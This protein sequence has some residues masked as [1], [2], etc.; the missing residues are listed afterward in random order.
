[1]C[2]IENDGACKQV[3]FD[4]VRNFDH[5]QDK[6]K[7]NTKNRMD[8]VLTEPLGNSVGSTN[9]A[10]EEKV[11]FFANERGREYIHA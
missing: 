7:G 4:E 1:V 11:F 3:S 9:S 10:R 8:V 6:E 5:E 2:V